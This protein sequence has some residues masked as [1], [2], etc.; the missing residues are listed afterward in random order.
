MLTELALFSPLIVL[1]YYNCIGWWTIIPILIVYYWLPKCIFVKFLNTFFPS[2]ITHSQ[3]NNIALTFDDVPYGSCHEIVQLLDQ[4][5]MKGTLFVISNYIN[6][7]NKHILINAVKNGH[8][9]A[10]HGRTNSMHALLGILDLQ[11]EIDIC[12]KMIKD[13]YEEAGVKLPN[14][15]FY[16]PGCGLFTQSM[17][18]IVNGCNYNLALG[19]VYPNDPIIFCSLIN[20]YYLINHIERGDIIILH[21]RKW[22]I[23]LLQKLL[24]WMTKNNYKSITLDSLS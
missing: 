21:D 12:D 3:H 23:G 13:I 24:P 4:Y 5:D 7:G 8:Q 9:L 11:T 18:T 14:K 20:Y 15:M 10:N 16:R 6:E 22:T 17:L 2:I 19:S 1:K